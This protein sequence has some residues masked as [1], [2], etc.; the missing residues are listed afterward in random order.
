MSK[1]QN[2]LI[3]ILNSQYNLDIVGNLESIGEGLDFLIYRGFSNYYGTPVA[4]RVPRHKEIRYGKESYN[5]EFFL[6]K[7]F[8]IYKYTYDSGLP[9]PFPF[10]V[11]KSDDISFLVYEYLDHDL[12]SPDIKDLGSTLSKLHKL[13]YQALGNLSITEEEQNDIN[14]YLLN[15]IKSRSNY[16]GT[17]IQ[18]PI[19]DHEFLSEIGKALTPPEQYSLLHLD[20]RKENILTIDNE[21]IGLIDWSYSMIGD[22]LLEIFRLDEFSIANDYNFC[23]SEF[24]K[25]YKNSTFN[26]KELETTK[27]M[28]YRLDAALMVAIVFMENSFSSYQRERQVKRALNLIQIIKTQL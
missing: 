24:F 22:P 11:Y 21:I 2:M 10:F 28:A 6:E 8:N 18:K 16:L 4:I 23:I 17:L 15:R 3:D 20:L 27:N 13:S 7:E 1:F 12:S 14:D 25:Y 5:S 9:V 26:P 19:V